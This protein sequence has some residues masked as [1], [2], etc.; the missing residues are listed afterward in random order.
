[1]TNTVLTEKN[2]TTQKYFKKMLVMVCFFTS[3]HLVCLFIFGRAGLH[4]C[5]QAVSSCAETGLLSSCGTR[6]SCC[7]GFSCCRAQVLGMWA[8]AVAAHGL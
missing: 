3:T 5:M 7:G 6:T 2:C 4:C 1:M 8:S